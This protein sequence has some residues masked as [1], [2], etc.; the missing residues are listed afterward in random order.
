MDRITSSANL[1]EQHSA[2]CTF[3]QVDAHNIVP[4][5][6][7]SHKREYG[8]R[9]IRHKIHR[10]I[11]DYLKPFPSF[12]DKNDNNQQQKKLILPKFNRKLTKHTCK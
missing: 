9:T 3:F 12:N 11:E 4:V 8:A 7:A 1:H 10:V 2:G 5:W 6:I